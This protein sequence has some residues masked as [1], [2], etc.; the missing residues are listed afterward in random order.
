MDPAADPALFWAGKRN[1]RQ[2]PI[3]PLQRNEIV[4]DSRIA[5]IIDRARKLAEEKAPQMKFASIFADLEKTIP[6]NVKVVQI[7]PSL[8][9]QNQVMLDMTLAAGEQTALFDLLK[10]LAGS[11][12]FGDAI[13]QQ[14]EPPKQSEPLYR[15]HLRTP[16]AQK[17]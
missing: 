2:V 1:R 7:H 16:Y 4:S 6:Y 3:L 15:F 11:D 8:D 12:R 17:L 10:A 13:P 5:K 14:I 9:S